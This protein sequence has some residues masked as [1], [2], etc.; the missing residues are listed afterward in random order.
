MPPAPNELARVVW[1]SHILAYLDRYTHVPT[2]VPSLAEGLDDDFVGENEG[3]E[4]RDDE[5]I[6]PERLAAHDVGIRKKF[7]NCVAELL[8]N[9]K[10]GDRVMAT[11]MRE[12]EDAIEVDIASNGGF[13]PEDEQYL[14][15]LSQFLA[16]EGDEDTAE[17]RHAFLDATIAYNAPRIDFWADGL[18]KITRKA[19]DLSKERRRIVE[20]ATIAMQSH[21]DATLILQKH[22]GEMRPDV[23]F[24]WL[25]LLARPVTGLK[26]LRQVAQLL[27][28]FRNVTF[29]ALVPP[30]RISL[31]KSQI[32]PTIASAWKRLGLPKQPNGPPRT[33]HG[34]DAK[35]KKECGRELPTHCEIQLVTRHGV[36]KTI[37]IDVNKRRSID[38]SRHA[39]TLYCEDHSDVANEA[40]HQAVERCPGMTVPTRV[41]GEVVALYGRPGRHSGI[42]FGDMNLACFRHVLD[43][44]STY[45]DSEVHPVRGDAYSVR[46]L[47]ISCELEHALSGDELFTEVSVDRDL[48]FASQVSQLSKLL[49]YEMRVCETDSSRLE[50]HLALVGEDDTGRD[51]ENP[52]AEALMVNMD[53]SGDR[54]GKAA[55]YICRYCHD[56]LGSVFRQ[57]ASGKISQHSVLAEAIPEKLAAWREALPEKLA[58][59]REAPLEKLAE[60][61]V[62]EFPPEEELAAGREARMEKLV[63]EREALAEKLAPERETRPPGEADIR[64]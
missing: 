1:A 53:H 26:I 25:R 22:I 43:Y 7:L 18:V 14:D 31:S 4:A 20:A 58:A 15:S 3:G 59:R 44:F 61:R 21:E 42:P 38:L 50:Q 37:F 64:E 35:F 23:V 17:K 29:I 33:L 11:A 51:M 2:E 40:V 45:F 55:E 6:A 60:L 52:Y 39:L 24:R 5:T 46:A 9:V 32:P 13:G 19:Q 62:R 54:W 63:A 27:P 48:P 47:K 12:S 56:V 57:F 36:L 41:Y 8:S 30:P 28:N 10:G 16:L 49:G 34:K